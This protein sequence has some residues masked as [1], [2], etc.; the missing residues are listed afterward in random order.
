MKNKTKLTINV[1]QI[2][3][4]KGTPI[5]SP[6]YNK[7]FRAQTQK[8]CLHPVLY[9]LQQTKKLPRGPVCTK[10]CCEWTRMVMWKM[11]RATHTGAWQWAQ[12]ALVLWPWVPAAAYTDRALWKLRV[13][14]TYISSFNPHSHVW[15]RCYTL[16]LPIAKLR[17]QLKSGRSRIWIQFCR[18]SKSSCHR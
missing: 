13:S 8:F 12:R 1:F 18:A 5:H 6:T 3:L 14:I 2:S 4:P 16:N 15:A 10:I 7:E 17:S 9:L 11:G